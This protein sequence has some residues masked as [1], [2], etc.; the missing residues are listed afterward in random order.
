MPRKK[1]GIRVVREAEGPGYPQPVKAQEDLKDQYRQEESLFKRR[2][3]APN[4]ENSENQPCLQHMAEL[5]CLEGPF[6]HCGHFLGQPACQG[7]GM[8]R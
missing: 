3:G 4:L 5:L 8:Q 1:D 6:Q 7:T 2:A